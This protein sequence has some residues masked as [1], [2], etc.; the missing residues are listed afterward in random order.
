MNICKDDRC[1]RLDVHQAHAI[2]YN[3]D[4]RRRFPFWCR[5]GGYIA[6]STNGRKLDKMRCM[7]CGTIV[8]KAVPKPKV[9][10]KPQGPWT[11]CQACKAK[12]HVNN[13]RCSVCAGSGTA[14]AIR[15]LQLRK[16]GDP[17]RGKVS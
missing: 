9:K 7:D 14:H 11:P 10:P 5:C 12:G 1:K 15:L 3:P 16:G 13:V 8:P 4:L 17:R 6:R 2:T